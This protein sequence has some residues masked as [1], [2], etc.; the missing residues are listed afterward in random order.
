MYE[1]YELERKDGKEPLRIIEFIT[2]HDFR[3]C[4]R[5]A[6]LLL[7]KHK[8]VE[9]IRQEIGEEKEEFV[10]EVLDQWIANEQ[11]TAAPC[12]W[13]DLVKCMKMAHLDK[14]KVLEIEACVCQ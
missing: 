2:S 12:T 4:S 9:Q 14:N 3:K 13:V 5:L 6:N 10:C 1:L 8:A 7:R 11:G